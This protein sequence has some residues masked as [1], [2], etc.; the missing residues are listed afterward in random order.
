MANEEKK[1]K[2]SVKECEETFTKTAD[3]LGLDDDEREEFI[4]KCMTR[5]GHKP[6][7]T[8][9]DPEPEG[10]EGKTGSG[11]FPGS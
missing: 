9:T 4:R 5:A 3:M 8:W 1:S 11:W 6:I 7:L 10:K 2:A